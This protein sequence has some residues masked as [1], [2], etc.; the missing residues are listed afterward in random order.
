VAFTV[1]RR[2]SAKADAEERAR[3]AERRRRDFFMSE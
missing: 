1:R 3:I 2:A